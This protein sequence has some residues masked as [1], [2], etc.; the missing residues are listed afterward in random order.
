VLERLTARGFKSLSDLSIDLAPVTVLFGPNAVGKSNIVD[1]LQVLSR[2]ATART[3]EEALAPPVRGYPSEMF[4][5]PPGGLGELLEQPFAR[6]DLEADIRRS[7]PERP[8]RF[9][10][11]IGVGLAPRTGVLTNADEALVRLTLRGEV[12]GNPRIERTG[13]H[14]LVRANR[15]GHPRHIEAPLNYALI[16]DPTLT[17]PYFRDIVDVRAELASWRSYYLDPSTLMRTAAP[18][19]EVTDIGPRG[20]HL[21]PFLYYL[22]HEHPARFK[23]VGRAVRQVIPTV[24]AVDVKLD[25]TR[26]TLDLFIEQ[27]GVVVSSRIISEG[28]L[29]LLAL[30]CIAA[31]PFPAG[32][33]AFEEP[34]NGV[35]PRRI[36]VVARF[37]TEAARR[38]QVVVTTHSPT[39]LAEMLRVHRENG[40]GRRP[41]VAIFACLLDEGSTTVRPFPDPGPLLADTDIAAALTERSEEAVIEAMY[42]RGWLDG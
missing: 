8:R 40:N 38:A 15:Q 6:F 37:L 12:T 25:T 21:A 3:I 34:E 5:L 33:V 18:P 23:A 22:K 4:T 11:R 14:F 36:E 19:R 27:D 30:A 10:Y 39:F 32:L 41:A 24:R 26:G 1:A 42:V 9:R 13:G 28:T 16:S 29:R 17:R 20:E 2:I 35:H 31:T 7:G